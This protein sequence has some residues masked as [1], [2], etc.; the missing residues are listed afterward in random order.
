MTTESKEIKFV[1]RDSDG[2]DLIGSSFIVDSGINW[3]E[4]EKRLAD[5]WIT[6]W[7]HNMSNEENLIHFKKKTQEETPLPDVRKLIFE[8][9]LLNLRHSVQLIRTDTVF[10][11]TEE[12]DKHYEEHIRLLTEILDAPDSNKKLND[13]FE[14][15]DE[16]VDQILAEPGASG[17]LV[18]GME[19]FYI[20]DYCYK[21]VI[22][23]VGFMRYVR[24][25]S[26]QPI[27]SIET[28]P[29]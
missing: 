9:D 22:I 1:F 16:Y 6:N 24:H 14:T 18:T 21:L 25:I 11:T 2:K 15:T 20:A 5:L 19:S 29:F 13:M 12:L 7:K 10:A 28:D 8:D 23:Q 26:K 17:A 27:T 3:I 4:L